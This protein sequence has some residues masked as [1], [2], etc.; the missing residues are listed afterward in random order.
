M[1]DREKLVELLA[2]ACEWGDRCIGCKNNL[3]IAAT[4]R[5]ERFGKAADHLIA[6]GVTVNNWRDVK[7]DPPNSGEHVLLCC[8]VKRPDGSAG[9]R[10]VC[11]GFYAAKFTET[12]FSDGDDIACEYS[13]EADEYY[14]LEGWYEVIKN[15]GDYSSIA[16]ADFVVGWM[17]LPGAEGSVS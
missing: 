2:Q 15:W 9:S 4:C 3:P 16:I 5:E 8:A 11:D 7:T 13:E 6:N 1:T 10:Y 17:P 12:V 14:L